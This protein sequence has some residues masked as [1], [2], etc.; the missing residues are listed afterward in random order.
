VR[1]GHRLKLDLS[2][3]GADDFVA[4]RREYHRH[5]QEDFFASH[6]IAGTENYV[7]KRGESLW[8]IAQQR[9]DMPVWLVAQ[10]NP[11]VNFNDVRPGTQIT[12][13]RVEGINR[14]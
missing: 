7:V 10:Y 2:K 3:V 8:T 4:A 14:Q 11:D 12:L 5:L 13:P 1:V 6:R 9:N